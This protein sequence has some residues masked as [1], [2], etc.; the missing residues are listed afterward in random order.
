MR[1]DPYLNFPGNAREAMEFYHSVFGGKLDVIAF[2]DFGG[3]GVP[4][5]E[6]HMVMHA[7][8]SLPNGDLLMCSDAPPSFGNVTKGNS[9]HVMVG[10]ESV[11]EAQ[12]VYD[13]LS[14]GG[15]VHMELQE[16]D[17]A[18]RYANFEDRYGINWMVFYAGNR[19]Q[20]SD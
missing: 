12:R 17:W 1:L 10:V 13:G 2:K 16:T 5:S 15:K 18:E 20:A 7:S 9:T 19:S 4:E 11:D 8:I 14:A 6:Q 3:G